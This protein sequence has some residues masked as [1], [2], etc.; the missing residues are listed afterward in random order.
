MPCQ[1][2]CTFS[3]QVFWPLGVTAESLSRHYP[4][5]IQ[6]ACPRFCSLH[7]A[8]LL[9]LLADLGIQKPSFVW[10]TPLKGHLSSRVSCPVTELSVEQHCSSSSLCGVQLPEPLRRSVSK[11][12]PQKASSTRCLHVSVC[13][14]GKPAYNSVISWKWSW[15]LFE[16]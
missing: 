3:Y 5:L 6:A 10:R 16:Q 4:L 12:T 14:S 15:L 2:H 11:I 13:F 1:D 8:T 7:K 9:Y